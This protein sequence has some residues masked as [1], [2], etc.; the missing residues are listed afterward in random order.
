MS[1]QASDDL[2]AML[3]REY[4]RPDNQVRFE[5][6]PGAIVIW[7]NRV[8]Q[9]YTAHDYGDFPRHVDRIF[10]SHFDQPQTEP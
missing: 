9:N 6:S 3:T 7:D 5:W 2:I 10:L 1:P 4:D 8:V